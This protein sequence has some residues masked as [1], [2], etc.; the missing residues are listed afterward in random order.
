MKA[1]VLKQTIHELV[2][3]IEDEEVLNLYIQ[4]LKREL[5]RATV[6]DLFATTPQD[7]L[8]RAQESLASVKA[9]H[10][11]SIHEFKKEVDAWKKDWPT[12]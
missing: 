1:Q 6:P 8:N 2:E 9:G 11:R 12:R 7:M 5:D 10:T 3:K 4:L